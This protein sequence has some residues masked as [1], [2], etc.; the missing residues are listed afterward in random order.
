MLIPIDPSPATICAEGVN[1]L[2]PLVTRGTALALFVQRAH[3]ATRGEAF[4]PFHAL[5]GEVYQGLVEAV[6]DI[7]EGAAA[8]GAADSLGAATEIPVRELPSLDGLELCGPI[9]TGLKDFLGAVYA[10]YARCEEMGLVADAG[11]L[12][13]VAVGVRKLGWK[14]FSHT[15]KAPPCG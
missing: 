8:L 5:F 11:I 15:L 13:G 7:A 10:A 4:G 14:V 12:Q 2:T 3:W 9:A 1:L 6:D